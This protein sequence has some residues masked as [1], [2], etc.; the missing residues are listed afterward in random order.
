MKFGAYQ[1]FA[2]AVLSAFCVL[3]YPG[4]G[5][6]TESVAKESS[7]RSPEAR[8]DRV[9]Y[10]P[11]IT[12]PFFNEPPEITTE[13]KPVYILNKLPKDFISVAGFSTKG[14]VN[15]VGAQA[16]VRVTDKIGIILTKVGWAD[17]DFSDLLPDDDGA[18]NFTLGA[19]Y[20]VVAL[21]ET[22]TFLTVGGRYEAPVGDIESGQLEL[23]G[24]GDG[25]WDT[26]LA[27]GS[28]VGDRVGV[29]ASAGINAAFDMDH[30]TSSFH[31]SVHGDVEVVRGLFG[32][33]EANMLTTI[34]EGDRTDSSVLGSFEGYDLFNFGSTSSGTVLTFGLGARYRLNDHLAFGVAYELPVTGREDIIDFRLTADFVVHL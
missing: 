26:F 31:A 29:Q 11:P 18:L 1:C 23:Q 17:V 19:K 27:F 7:V 34:D 13:I 30:D 3:S 21:P 28:T 33:F 32:V 2:T 20:Q 9:R 14:W 24:G 25:F 15:L 10:V 6:A 22:N 12:S 4:T 5:A 16:R 8:P